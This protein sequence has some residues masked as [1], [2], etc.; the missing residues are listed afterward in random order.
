MYRA[1]ATWEPLTPH[2]QARN[3]STFW[4]WLSGV[5]DAAARN[6]RSFRAFCYS[7]N[8]ENRFLR[9]CAATLGTLDEVDTLISSGEWVDVLAVFDSQLLAGGTS[10][11]KAVALLAGHTW[12]VEDPGGGESMLY[13]DAAVLALTP[14]E[15][16]GARTWLQR[17]NRGDVEATLAIRDWMERA[18]SSLPSIEDVDP[19]MLSRPHEEANPN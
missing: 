4:A 8:A 7:A 16:E 19:A 12:N 3:F 13:Y 11:L 9:E 17:Y 5:R 6:G 14:E 2:E 1:F 15:R 10:G 18:S